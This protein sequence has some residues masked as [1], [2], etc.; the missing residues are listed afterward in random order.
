[1]NK[2][3]SKFIE[4]CSFLLVTELLRNLKIV[5]FWG[6]LLSICLSII[7]FAKNQNLY[8]YVYK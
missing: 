3:K 6:F 8:N 2:K 4:I 5:D 7:R 1:M